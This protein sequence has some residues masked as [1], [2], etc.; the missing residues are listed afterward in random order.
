[1]YTCILMEYLH[2]H[3]E[4]IDEA[5]ASDESL[6]SSPPFPSALKVSIWLLNFVQPVYHLDCCDHIC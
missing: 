1:M 4:S 2:L 3:T 5:I 6:L